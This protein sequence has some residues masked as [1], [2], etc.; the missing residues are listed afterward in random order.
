MNPF[1]I[2]SSKIGG[3]PLVHL[4]DEGKV[5]IFGKL[6]SVNPTGSIKD[7]A[8]F[9][10]LRR[11]YQDGRIRV[12]D[13]VVEPTSG[14]T[15]IGLA[16]VGREIGVNV[17]LTMP[18]NMSKERVDM[19]KAYGASVVLT[20]PLLGMQGAIDKAQEIAKGGAYIP[21]QFDNPAN[22]EIH[23]LTTA[24]E[25]FTA[26]P[27]TAYIISPLGSGGTAMGIKDYIL[28]EGLSARV[29]AVEPEKS[30]VLLGE[31]PGAHKIQ[32]IGANFVPSIVEVDRLDGILHVADEEAYAAT[33]ELYTRFGLFCGISSGSALAGAQKLL[34]TIEGDVVIILPD[35]GDRYRSTGVFDGLLN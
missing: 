1:G 2:I 21:S 6:E 17:I 28:H 22:R 20:D 4:Y 10:M 27:T 5:R 7:R 11:A 24:P 26:L 14:N 13:T 3:T 29:M 33:R 34:P 16:Y 15:G 8:A 35:S 12:H 23:A 31:Q 30:R 19:L 25:I 32:G 18:A 9:N